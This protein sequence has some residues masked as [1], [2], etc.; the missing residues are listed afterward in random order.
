[1]AWLPYL[2][3]PIFDE[4]IKNI[5]NLSRKWIQYL[6][7]GIFWF[8]FSEVCRCSKSKKSDFLK[9]KSSKIHLLLTE[10][11][12]ISLFINKSVDNTFI[13]KHLAE[14]EL[15]HVCPGTESGSLSYQPADDAYQD[16]IA[17]IFHFI[18]LF[19]NVRV[20]KSV[21]SIL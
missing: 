12:K 18:S 1:M 20:R 19:G 10:V 7:Y 3:A 11:S 5:R 17:M 15:C 8:V 13:C 4:F 9:I 2:S 6:R 16:K 14:F 21:G